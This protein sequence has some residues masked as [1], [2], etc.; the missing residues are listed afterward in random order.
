MYPNL[1]KFIR[2]VVSV[3]AAVV[4]TLAV[5]AAAARA[6]GET[7][8]ENAIE[9][10]NQAQ[11]IHEKGDL[12]SAIKLYEKALKI[13][14]NFP[15]AEYQR[16]IAYLALGKNVE[17]EAAF[18]RAF[19]LR[20]DWSLAETALGSLLVQKGDHSEAEKL[21]SHVL[22]NDPQNPPALIAMADLR[23]QTG[24]SPAILRE[25][26]TK[27]APLTGKANPTASLWTA[28]AALESALNISR[29]AK[30]SL[31]NA[32]AIDSKNRNAL[33]QLA[34]LAIAEG[35][36]VRANELLKRLDDGSPP[37]DRLR[38]LRASARAFDG[39]Y[40]AAIAQL[41]AIT[42]PDP[43]AKQLR[44]RIAAIRST[45][46]AELEKE[47][48]GDA[49]NALLLGRLCVL[50]RKDDPVKALAY[51]RRASEAEPAN[52]NHAIGFGAALVQAKEFES[53]AGIL[54]K[55]VDIAPDN[56]TVRA[57]LG[58]ALFQLKRY[59][60]AAEQFRWLTA[61]QPRSAGAY[62]FLGI[63]HDELGEY[64][65]AAANYQQYLRLADPVENKVDID[66]VNL[67]MPQIEKLI[68]EGKGKKK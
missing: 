30:A 40:D 25:L 63:V 3:G 49:K 52:I 65:D 38:L 4:L 23:L 64:M 42:G 39:D 55:I 66:K 8:P 43:G 37:S 6:Q 67:R 61:A 31:A 18:R 2:M 56:A 44:R 46:P 53:A 27:I 21:L 41:D 13:L 26:L 29:D 24:V 36:I 51:C 5:A 33:F 1:T 68:K 32:L 47:L 28:R 7:E 57:N 62:L 20:P 48:S 58:A 16:G 11:D 22:E 34:D 15:E 45:D 12:A 35:D 9:V 54:K 14:P 19:E 60:E 50:Y 59:A 17:T 10:F